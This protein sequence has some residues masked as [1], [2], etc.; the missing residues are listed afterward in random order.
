ML[1]RSRLSDILG[2][3]S[4][5]LVCVLLFLLSLADAGLVIKVFV[6]ETIMFY[7]RQHGLTDNLSVGRLKRTFTY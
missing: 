4:V 7:S 5:F 1:D 6:L 2:V 3:F